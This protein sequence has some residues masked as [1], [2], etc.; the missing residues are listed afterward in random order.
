MNKVDWST[1]NIHC[2]SIYSMMADGRK[3]TPLQTYREA[4]AELERKNVMYEKLK[5]KDGPKGEKLIDEIGELSILVPKL[6]V[7]KDEELPLSEGCKTFLGGV[8]ATQKYGKWSPS[9]DIG[10]KQTEKGKIVE[11]ES[12]GLVSVLDGVYLKK[13]EERVV[14]NWFSGH[15]DAFEGDDILNAEII[16]DVKSPWDIETYFSYLGKKLPDQYYW[17]MQ[18]YMALC[19]A[20]IAY[21][22]FCLVDTPPHLIKSA[23]DRLLSTLDV[24]SRE[25]PEYIEAEET[26]M[27]NMTFSDIPIRERRIKFVVERNDEDIELARKRVEKCREWLAEFEN[28]HLNYDTPATSRNMVA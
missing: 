3:K 27:N 4:L 23:A 15:P 22:H 19:N 7:F 13:N 1:V 21:V 11:D 20:Q 24:I 5:K 25:S 18:G 16:H 17:Q 6:E 14:D 9:K 8:Y 10:S 28:L 26:L 12:L 2:S